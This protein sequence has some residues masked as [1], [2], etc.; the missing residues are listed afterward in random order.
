MRLIAYV[1]VLVLLTV[2]PARWPSGAVRRMAATGTVAPYAATTAR[3]PGAVRVLAHLPADPL[4]PGVPRPA[5]ALPVAAPRIADALS[6][7]ETRSEGARTF[8]PARSIEP[9]GGSPAGPDLAEEAVPDRVEQAVPVGMARAR[10]NAQR[11]GTEGAVA[12]VGSVGSVAPDMMGPRG[13]ASGWRW[14]LAMPTRPIRRFDPPPQRWLAGHRG[15]D[16]AVRPGEKVM[17]A[18]PGVVGLAERVAGRGVVT[19]SHSDGLRT[20]YLPV[21]ALVRPGDVVAA[22]QV[23]GIVEE[24][25]VAHCTTVCLHWGLLRGRLY[26]DPLLLFGR[27]Q[28][29]LLPRWRVSEARRPS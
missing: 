21:R 25:A 23:I 7:G 27:G 2:A 13:D 18:G 29:R 16:L 17:A 26:L 10:G 5:N 15:V 12:P 19:I 6:A 20:T 4:P 3:A 1:L 11:V 9:V 22:G 8:G 14:P 24:D 28:V